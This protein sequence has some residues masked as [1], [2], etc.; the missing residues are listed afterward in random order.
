MLE[1]YSQIRTAHIWAISL[2]GF[3]FFI[4]AAFS[5]YGAKWP[6]NFALR[7]FVYLVDITL[8]TAAAMLWTILPKEMFENGWLHVKVTLVILYILAGFGAMRDKFSKQ[9]RIGFYILAALLFTTI[10]GIARTHSPL[11]WIG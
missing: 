11:S 2:S 3:L 6:R 9:M 8:L 4:R 1:F 5:I 7:L 10:I